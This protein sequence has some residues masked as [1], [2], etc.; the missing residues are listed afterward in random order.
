MTTLPLGLQ[1]YLL[2][3]LGTALLAHAVMRRYVL[4]AAAAAVASP[5]VFMLV[6]TVHGE[7][8]PPMELP[9]LALFTVMALVIALV[10]GVPF[11]LR[12]RRHGG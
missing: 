9:V 5:F 12:R 8:V 10:A 7:A 4:A 3:A 6:C 11:L 1:I 2:S